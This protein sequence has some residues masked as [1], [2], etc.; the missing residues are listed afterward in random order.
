MTSQVEK[1][2]KFNAIK[3]VVARGVSEGWWQDACTKEALAWLQS[4]ERNC[5]DLV[6]DYVASQYEAHGLD[7]RGR[8]TS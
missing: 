5:R 8:K 3:N 2:T 7:S 1:L 6:R 4:S